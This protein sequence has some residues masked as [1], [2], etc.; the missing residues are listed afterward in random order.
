MLFHAE[1][2]LQLQDQDAMSLAQLL[3]SQQQLP[4]SDLSL[5][6]RLVD[7]FA[8]DLCSA[9]DNGPSQKLDALYLLSSRGFSPTDGKVEGAYTDLELEMCALNLEQGASAWMGNLVSV[10]FSVKLV[11]GHHVFQSPP[12]FLIYNQAVGMSVSL[13]PF[14]FVED[15]GVVAFMMQ[16]EEK[17][18]V[19]FDPF[20]EEEESNA[21]QVPTFPSFP[22][23]AC[24]HVCCL[25]DPVAVLCVCAGCLQQGH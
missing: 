7:L 8:K 16:P 17:E 9:M 6:S 10:P 20:R 23:H 11:I 15:G 14:A 2:L 12:V 18:L 4:G 3:A 24:W 25:S 5:L 1:F 13:A 19:I 21:K 22:F